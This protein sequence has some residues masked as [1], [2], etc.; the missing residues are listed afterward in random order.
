MVQCEVTPRI[1][2]GVCDPGVPTTTGLREAGNA[3][4][5]MARAEEPECYPKTGSLNH[6]PLGTVASVSSGRRQAGRIE[7]R[8]GCADVPPALLPSAHHLPQEDQR[9]PGNR[10]GRDEND[11]DDMGPSVRGIMLSCRPGAEDSKN[12]GDRERYQAKQ[13]HVSQHELGQAC[14]DDK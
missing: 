3:R 5:I 11:R 2:A 7:S 8:R 4:P 12:Q 10:P 6:A 14:S 1:V 9:D 13:D